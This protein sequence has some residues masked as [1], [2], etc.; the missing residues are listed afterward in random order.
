MA[1]EPEDRAGGHVENDGDDGEHEDEQ[2]ADLEGEIGQ[3]AVGGAEALGFVLLAGEGADDADAGDLFAQGAVH[4]VELALPGA[5]KRHEPDD[6]EGD[7][8]EQYD[9][10]H[11]DEPGHPGV[12]AD[13]H[14]D[15]ADGHDRR[16]D[17]EVEHHHV[18]HLDLLDVVGAAGDEG[19]GAEVVHVLGGVA[20]DAA[21]DVGA[22]VAA[23]AHGGAGAEP[24]GG[25]GGEDLDEGHDE[26][27]AA[28]APDVVDVNLGHASVDDLRVER[29]QVERCRGG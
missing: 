11:R 16:G 10:G 29:R 3:V 4:D 13:G 5:E 20:G 21:E 9:D 12:F 23:E 6:D 15:A 17:H 25:D 27:D 22:Q 7:G 14:D 18:D 26:H 24:D 19:G 28:G 2:L 1:A 8:S